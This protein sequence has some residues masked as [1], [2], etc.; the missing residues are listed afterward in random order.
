MSG[1]GLPLGRALPPSRPATRSALRWR[2]GR[3]PGRVWRGIDSLPDCQPAAFGLGHRA[4]GQSTT[5]PTGGVGA[6]RVTRGR[7]DYHFIA[8]PARSVLTVLRAGS[9][10]L[11]IRPARGHVCHVRLGLPALRL[12]WWG[13]DERS[14]LGPSRIPPAACPSASSPIGS[15][16]RRGG[17][18]RVDATRGVGWPR[19]A[20]SQAALVPWRPRP[21]LP[22]QR[23]CLTQRLIFAC[24]HGVARPLAPGHPPRL[25]LTA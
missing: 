16:W 21:H 1:P 4:A 14:G 22:V 11:A 19:P 2:P 12:S 17:A 10:G 13:L 8:D 9:M 7:Y 23:H 25:N 5:S 24:L 15:T 3:R 18:G 20:G 6:G